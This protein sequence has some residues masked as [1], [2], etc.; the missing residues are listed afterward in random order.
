MIIAI[1]FFVLCSCGAYAADAVQFYSSDAEIG[2]FLAVL[3]SDTVWHD[4]LVRHAQEMHE[5][6]LQKLYKA[7]LFAKA[8]NYFDQFSRTWP[9]RVAQAQA[10]RRAQIAIG[11]LSERGKRISRRIHV[12]KK[13]RSDHID[14]EPAPKRFKRDARELT[15]LGW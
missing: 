7:Y 5:I 1:T 6:N 8:K 11:E 10:E 14:D 15:S 4:F 9:A 12:S 13:R 2:Q 3:P